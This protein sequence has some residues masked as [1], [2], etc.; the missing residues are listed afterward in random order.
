[1]SSPT[2]V[3]RRVGSPNRAVFSQTLRVTPPTET[4]RVPGLLSS[5]TSLAALSPMIST[6]AAPIPT[7]SFG[8]AVSSFGFT[9][10]YYTPKGGF[11]KGGF[12]P[13]RPGTG[14]PPRRGRPRQSR[15]ASGAEGARRREAPPTC[16]A[17]PARCSSRAGAAQPQK[18]L[19][20]SSAV[21]ALV[22]V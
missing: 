8:K 20:S 12:L 3:I 18:R 4:E 6:L 16:G 5:I 19:S 21:L 7:I 17:D 1:M 22:R 14:K 9:A 13:Q 2:V 11:F 15:G 10:L